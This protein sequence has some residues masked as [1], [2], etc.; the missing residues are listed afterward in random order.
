MTNP[1]MSNGATFMSVVR[2]LDDGYNGDFDYLAML[3]MVSLVRRLRSSTDAAVD[4]VNLHHERKGRF[5]EGERTCV[6]CHTVSR[7]E[8]ER[9]M[10]DLERMK[11]E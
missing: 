8:Y 4:L 6:V 11:M 7:T 3:E 1:D 10:T 9:C 5:D 2:K